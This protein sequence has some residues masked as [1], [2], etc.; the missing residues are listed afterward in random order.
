MKLAVRLPNWVGDACMAL[1]A[2]RALS[3]RGL[4]LH[5]F[6]K[7]WAGDLFAAHGWP[8]SKLPAGVRPAITCVRTAG[9][10][11]GLL[12]TNSFGSAWQWRL[13]GV[14]AV[15]YRRE[16]RSL[17]LGRGVPRL[18]GVHEV[19]AFWRLAQEV[20]TWLALPPLPLQPPAAL[21]LQLTPAHHQAADEA[22]RRCGVHSPFIVLCPLAAG[23]INGQPKVWPAF[24]LLARLISERGLPI[25]ACPGPGEEAACAAALPG[26]RLL[27]GLALGAYAAVCSRALLTVANDSGPMH[28]AAAVD[29]P[30]I[31]I[32]G[33][34]DPQRTRPW[35]TAGR[36]IGDAHTWPTAM[37]VMRALEL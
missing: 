12:L 17:L 25:V 11:H 14:R 34:G 37:T 31:G 7:G 26:A 28:L 20:A 2:L 23:T 9:A 32:F 13:A 35:S 1:P 5:L 22:L 15:G 10:T 19:E 3:E 30:V 6:G 29:A 8:V 33:G 4:E 21:G 36:V 16:C 18:R 27:P 24:A